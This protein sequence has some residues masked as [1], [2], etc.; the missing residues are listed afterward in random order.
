[1]EGGNSFNALNFTVGY[2]DATGMN[3]TGAS[4]VVNVVH[5]PLRRRVANRMRDG[6]RPQ[7]SVIDGLRPGLRL[8]RLRPDLYTDIDPNGIHGRPRADPATPY[9]NKASAPTACSSRARPR[10]PRSPT[11]P[12]NTIAIGEDAGRDERFISPYTEI[13]YDRA[14][15]SRTI[16]GRPGRPTLPTV[17]TGAG[18]SPTAPS[19]SPAARTTSTAR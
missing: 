14:A 17:A 6:G 1:M 18:P 9:R 13:Y 5:L 3:F 11:A 2:N 10:S 19:A 4:A 8:H 16:L 15:T 7:R 12:S